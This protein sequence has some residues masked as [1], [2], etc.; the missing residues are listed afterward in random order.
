[1]HLHHA[2]TPIINS[3]ST[4]PLPMALDRDLVQPHFCRRTK[5]SIKASIVAPP[6]F[7]PLNQLT[8]LEGL[9]KPLAVGYFGEGLALLLALAGG[10]RRIA[11][12]DDSQHIQGVRDAQE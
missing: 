6:F 12:R 3:S 5:A 2:A 4:I 10:L 1:M 11:E 7:E 8:S 9:P